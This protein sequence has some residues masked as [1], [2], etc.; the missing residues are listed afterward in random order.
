VGLL[1]I[2]IIVYSIGL[3]YN[4]LTWKVDVIKMKESQCPTMASS[5]SR[6]VPAHEPKLQ[7]LASPL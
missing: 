7:L 4:F 6:S 2:L 3:I 5:N 1:T